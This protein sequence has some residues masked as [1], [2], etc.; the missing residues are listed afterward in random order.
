[1]HNFFYMFFLPYPRRGS[2]HR[3]SLESLRTAY[4]VLRTKGIP[5]F[6]IFLS[7][8]SLKEARIFKTKQVL[9]LL[10][11]SISCIVKTRLLSIVNVQ[12]WKHDFEEEDYYLR[13]FAI[14]NC[15]NYNDNFHTKIL[16]VLPDFP[17]LNLH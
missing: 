16:Y 5:F 4:H 15:T 1:M 8:R 7:L 13:N 17:F 14:S 10:W 3:R 9:N 12:N 6:F 2:G 11:I